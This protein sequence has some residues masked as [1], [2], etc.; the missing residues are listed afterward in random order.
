MTT[1]FTT[2][3]YDPVDHNR[4]H[5]LTHLFGLDGIGKRGREERQRRAREKHASISY[6]PLGESRVDDLPAKMVYGR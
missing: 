3:P 6:Q 5:I 1:S 2:A 4:P